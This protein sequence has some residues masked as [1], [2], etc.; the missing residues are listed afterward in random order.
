M[1]QRIK[2]I[3]VAIFTLMFAIL[4]PLSVFAESGTV[5][6]A[7]QIFLGG[8]SSTWSFT[9][10][11][12]QG[13]MDGACVDP[14]NMSIPLGGQSANLE[15]L[16]RSSHLC[17]LAYLAKDEFTTDVQQYAVGRAGARILGLTEYN[18]YNYSNV[19]N[20]IY[21]RAK[22]VTVPDGFEAWLVKPTNGSQ[23]ILSWRYSPVG[24]LNLKKTADNSTGIVTKYPSGF[25]LAGATYGVYSSSSLS[26]DSKVGTLITN[27]SG[28][29]NTLDLNAGTYY[30]VE[31]SPSKG[32]KKD[33]TV[34]T[35]T[36][37]SGQTATV[38]SVEPPGFGEAYI[39][40]SVAKNK[41]LTDLCPEQYSLSGAEFLLTNRADSSITAKLVTGENGITEKQSIVPGTYSVTETK[42]PKGYKINRSIPDVTITEGQVAEIKVADEPLF[43]PLSLKIQKKAE[44]GADKNLSLEGAE[45]TVKYFKDFLTEDEINAGATPFR[46]WVFRTDKN[47]EF[48]FKPKY[49]IGGDEL[50]L[51]D[52]NIPTGLHGAYAFYETKAPKGFAK[53]EGIISLQYVKPNETSDQVVVMKDV[54][55][56]EK[57]QKVNIQIQ[58][59][60]AE[61][62]KP[63]PQGY[64]SFK[65]AVFS[66]WYFNATE[67]KDT[68]VGTVTT[69]E[70]GYGSLDAQKPGLYT[71]KEE[72]APAGYVTNKK[73]VKVEARIREINTAFFDYKSKVPEKPITV[74]ITKSSINEK[75]EKVSVKGAV[76][77][78]YTSDGKKLEEWTTDGKAHILK[79][80]PKGEY[81]IKELK[82]PKGYLPLE[83]DFR[84]T[85]RE[86]EDVQ[87]KD[88]FNEPIPEVKTVATF[89][90]G[91]KESLP[92]EVVTVF[93]KF[94]YKKVLKGHPYEIRAK[95]VEKDN[96]SNVIAE[97]NKEFIAE[98]YKGIETL[99]FT[100]NAKDLKGKRLVVLTELHRL[101]RKDNT[102]VAVH[103]DINNIDETVV[104]PKINTTAKDKKDGGKDLLAGKKETIVDKVSY[105]NLIIGRKYKVSGKLMNKETGK[106]VLDN[107]KEITAEKEFTAET[108]SGFVN[109]EFIFNASALAGKTVVVFEDVYQDKIKVATHAEITDKEQSIYIPKIGTKL[110]GKDSEEKEFHA[111]DKI[112]L[113]DTMKYENLIKGKVYYAKGEIINKETGKA[114]QKAEGNFIAD[115]ENGEASLDFTINAKDLKGAELVCFEEIY[116]IDDEGSPDKLVGEHKD[117]NDKGQTVK[118][119]EPKIGTQAQ[120]NG[121]KKSVTEDKDITLI[122]RVSYYDLLIGKEYTIKGILM[123]KSTGKPLMVNGKEIRA[124][125]TFVAKAKNGEETLTFKF[126]GKGLGGKTVVV[127]ED[128]YQDRKLI[129]THSDINDLGQSIKIYKLGEITITDKDKFKRLSVMTG[130]SNEAIYYLLVI[131]ALGTVAVLINRRKNEK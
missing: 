116:T 109:L 129:G 68:K 54:T 87:K 3:G 78:L 56:E 22:S 58:K 50:F 28:N 127:F 4:T 114:I 81:V 96:V 91:T 63:E 83:E 106:P 36:V 85:V 79:A 49:K 32:F 46:T 20:S 77:A 118:I 15:K 97:D 128:V 8:G 53:T 112:E 90:T 55:A 80:L 21:D 57:T 66:V 37:T 39:K 92:K 60:D 35:V 124:E 9:V 16:D 119:V 31:I 100:F 98:N 48:F 86:T 44:N 126:S 2:Q 29:S 110:T 102:L 73:E 38:T 107:G 94:E 26:G 1:Q 61:T 120:A 52:K 113:R 42:A 33:L 125:K 5:T 70:N 64:G 12:G 75:G 103:K 74:E 123:D 23:M 43:D 95:L 76:L 101:D 30:V 7:R 67:G 105:T 115:E 14:T 17:K 131:L 24:H 104:I 121:G 108:S 71:I 45:Y 11:D 89:E 93:D 40:K 65:G 62:G 27:A 82:T 10:D 47:G 84:F 111:F 69:D 13:N 130:D 25:S 6:S 88:V 51:N 59:V 34:H 117:I 122:D 18:H 19:V 41:H 72:K 99:K